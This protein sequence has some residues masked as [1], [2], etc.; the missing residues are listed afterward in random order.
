MIDRRVTTAATV[1]L[2]LAGAGIAQGW[3]LLSAKLFS[4]TGLPDT[5]LFQGAFWAVWFPLA[6]LAA[7]AGILGAYRSLRRGDVSSG[8]L[9]VFA[10]LYTFTITVSG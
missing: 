9:T 3:T 1:V 2:V 5:G 8:W 10:I 6:C 7:F 4:S